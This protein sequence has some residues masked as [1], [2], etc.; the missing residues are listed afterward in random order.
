[1]K[2]LLFLPL[3][4][5]SGFIFAEDTSYQQIGPFGGLNNTDNP[6][7]IQTEK[8]QDLLNVDITPGGK[9]VKKRKG[10]AQAFQL[11]RSSSAAHGTHFF[12]DANGNDTALYF[13]DTYGYASIGGAEP[14]IIFSTGAVGATYQ[15]VDSQ[16][17]AYCAN[18]L[19][20]FILKTDGITTTMITS[21]PSTG[22]M[23]AV[24]PTRL[25]MAGFS[26]YPNRIDFSQSND[27]TNFTPGGY[28]YS[29]VNFTVV[30][31]GA[32][33]THIVYA[34]ERIY[35]FKNSS[36]GYILDGPTLAD[37]S[38][39]TISN[40]VGTN[41]NTS[42]YRDGILYFRGSDAGIYAY[43]GASLVNLTREIK[44]TIG[45][46]GSRVSNLWIQ[47]TAS[48]FGSGSSTST[49]KVDTTTVPGTIQLSSTTGTSGAMDTYLDTGASYNQLCQATYQSFTATNTYLMTSIDLRTYLFAG[50]PTYDVAILDDNAFAPGSILSSATF[51]MTG[52]GAAWVYQNTNLPDISITYGTRYWIKLT[53]VSCSSPDTLMFWQYK[54]AISMSDEKMIMGSTYLTK[55]FNYR[56]NGTPIIYSGPATWQS[57]V[58]NAASLTSWD[59]FRATIDNGGGSHDFYIRSSTNSFTINSSSPAWS[60]LTNGGIP[61]VSVGTYF[62]IRDVISISTLAI[63]PVLYDFT[64]NWYEGSASD[65]PYAIYHDDSILWSVTSGTGASTNNTILR[66]DL[67]NPNTW[68]IYDIPTNGMYIRNADLYF[69][70]SSTGVVYKFGDAD[71]DNGAAINAY[72]KSKDFIG[73]SPFVDN[74]YTNLSLSAAMVENSS[75]TVTYTINGSSSTSYTMPLNMGANTFIKYNK[76]LPLGRVGT[77]F[78]LQFGN[79][80]AD[81]P[82]EVFGA[83]YGFRPKPWTTTPR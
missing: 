34:H 20:N 79:N 43:D 73:I 64:Q 5:L 16:G 29:P 83:Q 57:S 28:S 70:G 56:V 38:L 3:F 8:A 55:R 10:Y 26:D 68:T 14:S 17:Y 47:T 66:Y 45:V 80:S 75:M 30:S 22:T 27:F 52:L 11:S 71:N 25:V 46:T 18:T 4:L 63:T 31:P 77:Y 59:S 58:K 23:L 39:R 41:D 82:F 32:K 65:K 50:S 36:F 61:P 19:R 42:V 40:D 35:W 51:N 49:I 33:I 76:N 54:D 15:C 6:L 60:Q 67:I 74:E 2:K 53:P 24:T 12:Y 62:Q 37:W 78:N 7:V 69:V 21:F 1:M 81:Q 72:W 48:D 9:S 13:N 44:D